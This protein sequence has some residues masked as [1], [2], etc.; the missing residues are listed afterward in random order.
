MIN[1]KKYTRL[2]LAGM[3]IFVLQCGG[4]HAFA[5]D[6]T[7]LSAVPFQEVHV[8]DS[9]WGPRIAKNREV[10]IEANL[11]QCEVT[12]RIKN[13]AVAGKLG[14]GQAPGACYSTTPTST[15]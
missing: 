15:R 11:R 9:F 14:A 3:A 12:G 8:A 4:K 10:T 1:E 5:A 2:F 13:F 6:N 7:R